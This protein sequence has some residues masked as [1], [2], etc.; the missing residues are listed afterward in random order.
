ML[1]TSTVTRIVCPAR[2]Q[3]TL[4]WAPPFSPLFRLRGGLRGKGFYRS[5]ESLSL[6]RPPG[7]PKRIV[8][9]RR[10]CVS[11]GQRVQQSRLRRISLLP[12]TLV[13]KCKTETPCRVLPD[14]LHT[15]VRMSITTIF[16]RSIHS[17]SQNF[18][19]DSG[20]SRNFIV[21]RYFYVVRHINYKHMK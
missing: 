19:F 3:V 16:V 21:C 1:C 13:V 12:P 20:N 10:R 5:I 8:F 7:E 2:Q 14:P 17:I 6:P 9:S 11:F 18:N 15:R 4:Y